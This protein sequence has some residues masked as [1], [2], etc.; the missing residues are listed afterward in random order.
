MVL[1]APN[2]QMCDSFYAAV[3]FKD[4]CYEYVEPF[5]LERLSD[6]TTAKL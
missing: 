4:R 5:K 1:F 2:F 6:Q 3:V